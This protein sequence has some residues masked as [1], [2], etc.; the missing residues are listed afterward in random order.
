MWNAVIL[1]CKVGYFH[2]KRVYFVKKPGY[3][4]PPFGLQNLKQGYFIKNKGGIRPKTTVFWTVSIE[5]EIVWR[6]V[7]WCFTR[8]VKWC[9]SELKKVLIL[10][11]FFSFL[12][13]LTSR[14]PPQATSDEGAGGRRELFRRRKSLAPH[15]G[16]RRGGAV[17]R[18]EQEGE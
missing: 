6:S 4:H 16:A 17:R 9:V 15:L 5:N 8:N 1:I 3:I 12:A 11:P 2:P 13:R 18:S 10:A 7:G 14:P